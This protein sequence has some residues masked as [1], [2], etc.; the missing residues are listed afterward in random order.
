LADAADNAHFAG[1]SCER[2][3]AE[4]RDKLKAH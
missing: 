1:A 2:R 4:A 3:Y